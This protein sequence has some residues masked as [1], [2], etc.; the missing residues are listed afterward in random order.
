MVFFVV[1]TFDSTL[2]RTPYECLSSLPMDRVSPNPSWIRRSSPKLY[3]VPESSCA[4]VCLPPTATLRIGP[5]PSG[6][7]TLT[8]VLTSVYS[9]SSSAPMGPF[10]F[11]GFTPD[12]PQEL[13]PTQYT[14][15]FL[16]T[17]AACSNPI[18]IC[19]MALLP[20]QPREGRPGTSLV[21]SST[22]GLAVE[23]E[24]GSEPTC[25]SASCVIISGTFSTM[26]VRPCLVNKYMAVEE[27]CTSSN[28][29]PFASPVK[30]TSAGPMKTES[31][32]SAG[33]PSPQ[34]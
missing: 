7:V 5:A 22:A 15:P 2:C 1:K 6:N 31:S 4:I 29:R 21:C 13:P 28:L 25:F 20:N 27:H 17:N 30:R 32:A 26:Y 12:C 11:S 34:T 33:R 3:N 14:S 18:A 23:E 9:R 8:G 10:C 19:L 24:A 16:V